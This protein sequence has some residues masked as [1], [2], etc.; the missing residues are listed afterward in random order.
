MPAMLLRA[1]MALYRSRYWRPVERMASRP[2][3]TQQ[4]VLR[5]LLAANR[6]TR[7]AASTGSRTFTITE[8]W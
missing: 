5:R 3:A 7:F 8:A 4:N 2:A 6:G 1:G